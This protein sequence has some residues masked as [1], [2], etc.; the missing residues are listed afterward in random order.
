MNHPVLIV[1]QVV[2]KAFDIYTFL[3]LARILMSWVPQIRANMALR[4]V[5]EFIDVATDVVLVPAREV[6]FRLLEAFKVNP[7][8]IP[9]DFSPILAFLL[10][11]FIRSVV[12]M[13]LGLFL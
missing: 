13:F 2:G 12:M 1:A 7:Y 4:P 6:Y 5:I 3:L 10:V 9:L 8:Q 11:G